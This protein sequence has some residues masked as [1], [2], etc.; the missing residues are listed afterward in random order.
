[1]RSRS[2]SLLLA[3]TASLALAG[4]ARPYVR[5]V[6][7]NDAGKTYTV[8]WEDPHIKMTV[9]TG[10]MDVVPA[11][12]LY[13]AAMRAAATWCDP[14]LGSTIELTVERSDDPHVDTDFD[15]MVAIP[16]ENMTWVNTISFKTASWDDGVTYFREQL[17]LTTLWNRGGR[18]VDA[19]TE[20]NGFDPAFPW[21]TLPDDPVE[22]AKL[23]T[24]IDLPAAL[25]HE[26]GHVVGLDH[27]C[28]LGGP[29]LGEKT[30][31]VAP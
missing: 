26:L 13:A 5:T 11:D 23:D 21:G 24:T 19:D 31:G 30:S 15:H 3:L 17:A 25:T 8:F 20:I 6:S 29:V 28:S 22:A 27:P 10:G 4:P 7:H 16:P 1:M 2:T 9:L 18:I 12:E 14:S